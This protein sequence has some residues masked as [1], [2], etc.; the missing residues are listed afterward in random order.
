MGNNSGRQRRE[1][2]LARSR[3]MERGRERRTTLALRFSRVF[4]PNPPTQHSGQVKE[5]AT[6]QTDWRRLRLLRSGG[7]MC[8]GQRVRAREAR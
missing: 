5:G 2:A 1:E 8:L 4:S 3:I 6:K 7:L